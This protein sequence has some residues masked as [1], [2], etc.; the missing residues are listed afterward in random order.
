[1]TAPDTGEGAEFDR[2]LAEAKRALA[3]TSVQPPVTS[4]FV[5]GVAFAV[6]LRARQGGDPREIADDV[7][8]RWDMLTVERLAELD[9]GGTR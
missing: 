5:W 6:A 2:K 1:M 3:T 9:E 4:D 8:L 7:A